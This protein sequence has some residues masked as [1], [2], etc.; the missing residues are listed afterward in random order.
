[1][2]G[3]SVHSVTARLR[4]LRARPTTHEL[5]ATQPLRALTTACGHQFC[6]QCLLQTTRRSVKCPMCRS[7]VHTCEDKSAACALCVAGIPTATEFANAR[8]REQLPT[9]A[10]L[11]HQRRVRNERA[12]E[13]ACFV[14]F[15]LVVTFILVAI[16][17][18]L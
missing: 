14:L 15:F 17:S 3:R 10:I 6:S 1:M 2:N 12:G 8:P 18:A 13:A 11:A 5:D 9:R 7:P 16:Y 4:R